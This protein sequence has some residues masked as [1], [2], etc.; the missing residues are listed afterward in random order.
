M[1]LFIFTDEIHHKSQYEQYVSVDALNPEY[2][3]PDSGYIF[4]DKKMGSYSITS[5]IFS[6]EDSTESIPSKYLPNIS[7]VFVKPI[8]ENVGKAHFLVFRH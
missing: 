8:L 2:P 5:S 3:A 1:G 7:Q 6:L 4:G